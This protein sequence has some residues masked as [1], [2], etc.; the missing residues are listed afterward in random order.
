MTLSRRRLVLGVLVGVGLLFLGRFGA[1]FVT[2]RLW[3]AEVSGPA[4]LVGTRFALLRIGLELLGVGSALAWFLAN[5][6][7]A[8]RATERHGSGPPR[9]GQLGG[10][11]FRWIAVGAAVVIGV[12]IGSGTRAWL[13]PV[14]LAWTGVSY[15]VPDTLLQRDLGMFVGRLPLWALLHQRALALV[16]LGLLG[17]GAIALLGG[18]LKVRERR[19]SLAP[20]LRG[21]FALL[22]A[23]LALLIAW[24]LALTPYLLAATR[25]SSLGPA[26]YLLRVTVAQVQTAFAATAAFLTL[27][28]GFRARLVVALGGWVGLGLAA[29]AGSLLVEGRSTGAPLAAVELATLRRVDSVGFGIA[30]SPADPYATPAGLGPALWDEDALGGLVETDSAR[31]PDLSV[32]SVPLGDRTARV[33]FALRPLPGGD[34][35]VLAV[36]DDRTGPGGGPVSLRAG[37]SVFSPGLVPYLTLQRSH[38]RPGAPPYVLGPSVG[39]VALSS[40]LRRVAIGW[41]LQVGEVLGADPADRL[42]WRLEPARRLEGVA[43]F[44]EWSRARG[45]VVGGEM[46]WLSDG[47]LTVERFPSSREVTWRGRA[48]RFAR[49]AFVGVVAARTGEARVFLRADADS[50]AHVWGRIAAPLVEPAAALPPW[51]AAEVGLPREQLAAQAQVLQGDAWLGRPVARF[52]RSLYPLDSLAALGT[53]LD[54]VTVPFL[55]LSGLDVTGVLAGPSRPQS[56]ATRLTT[57]DSALAPPAP[58]ELQQRWDRFPFFQQ[59]RDSIRAAGSEHQAGLIRYGTRGDTILAYQPNYAVGPRG[60]SVL[61]LVNVALGERLGAGRSYQEAWENLRGVTAPSPVAADLGG[62]LEQ[63]REWMERAQAALERGDLEEF[64]RAFNFLRDILRGGPAERRPP[65]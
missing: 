45:H 38:A 1:V 13:F 46:H 49:A 41:A 34:V 37:D 9:V 10:R 22:V 60:R 6:L 20:P 5:F 35:S 56:L 32:G 57:A 36:A 61:I 39:G 18:A 30:W 23:A 15:G 7:A 26:E 48:V 42:A 3:E 55:G 11:A 17:V 16:V 25:S 59:I 47:F 65:P 64:G 44:V 19:V 33:W 28:S 58:R 52:G 8:T 63:A 50:L 4:A 12:T 27:L 53:W 40:A 51:L 31:V 43:P 21:H 62:R 24:R 2:E 54:P 29:L 14:L